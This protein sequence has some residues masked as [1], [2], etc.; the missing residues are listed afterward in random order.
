MAL[1]NRY[2]TAVLQ[3]Q[4]I[5]A[6]QCTNNYKPTMQMFEHI[7][8]W[9]QLINTNKGVECYRYT[10]NNLGEYCFTLK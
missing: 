4:M 2:Q 6:A 10:G 5:V 9:F 3:Q 8:E 1:L 7:G